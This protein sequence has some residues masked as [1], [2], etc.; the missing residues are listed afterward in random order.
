[1][2]VQT[3]AHLNAE[4]EM[5]TEKRR[6][7]GP[8]IKRLITYTSKAHKDC[9]SAGINME[10][11]DGYQTSPPWRPREARGGKSVAEARR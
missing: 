5:Q 3:N 7:Q 8:I 9:I 2:L 4:R 10:Q 11:T 1:M 6:A